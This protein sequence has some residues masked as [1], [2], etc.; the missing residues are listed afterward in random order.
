LTLRAKEEEN[1]VLANGDLFE[2]WGDESA[3][4]FGREIRVCFTW[5][6]EELLDEG[7]RRVADVIKRLLATA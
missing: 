7:I 1:V 3:A 2:V 6:D 4:R 5:E